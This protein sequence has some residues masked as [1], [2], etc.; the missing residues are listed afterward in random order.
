MSFRFSTKTPNNSLNLCSASLRRTAYGS[1]VSLA[2]RRFNLN[3]LSHTHR[4]HSPARHDVIALAPVAPLAHSVCTPRAGLLSC[5]KQQRSRWFPG[6]RFAAQICRPQS[7][8]EHRFSVGWPGGE[9]HPP[10]QAV[11]APNWRFEPT[12]NRLAALVRFG[13]ASSACCGRLK[14]ALGPQHLNA[15]A[16]VEPCAGVRP[17]ALSIASAVMVQLF[18]L[19]DLPLQCSQGRQTRVQR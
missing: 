7:A 1:R 17:F 18:A 2:V 10:K 11:P 3:C 16:R 14:L 8:N 4:A 12:H 6:I 15:V 9:Y 13:H 5:A 19:G